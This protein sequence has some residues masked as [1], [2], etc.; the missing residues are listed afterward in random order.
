LS[1]LS[2]ASADPVKSIWHRLRGNIPWDRTCKP[3]QASQVLCG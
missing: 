2:V 3:A 1:E